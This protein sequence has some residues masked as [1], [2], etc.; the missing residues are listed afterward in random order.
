MYKG[1]LI[2]TSSYT[3]NYKICVEE[4]EQEKPLRDFLLSHI[5]NS[6]Y[7]YEYIHTKRYTNLCE[8]IL[9]T[10]FEFK[11][12]VSDYLTAKLY[13]EY[14]GKKSTKCNYVLNTKTHTYHQFYEDNCITVI[15]SIIDKPG[16][17]ITTKIDIKANNIPMTVCI[18]DECTELVNV[19]NIFNISEYE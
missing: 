4:Y 11:N 10:D 17:E 2:D 14:Y 5:R 15:A 18:W 13:K 1:T 12:E 9:K 19:L 7:D 3:F 8:I 16:S 6:S